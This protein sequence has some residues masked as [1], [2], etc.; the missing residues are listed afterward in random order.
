MDQSV[1]Y[2]VENKSQYTICIKDGA[3]YSEDIKPGAS[4]AI[5]S[6][7]DANVTV[8]IGEGRNKELGFAWIPAPGS[9]TVKGDWD[10]YIARK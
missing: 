5:L 8:L 7:H 3:Y 2:T 4:L 6:N 9:I 1:S 10:W